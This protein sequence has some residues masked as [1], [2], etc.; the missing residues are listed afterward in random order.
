M[1]I[2]INDIC[3]VTLDGSIVSSTLDVLHQTAPFS[4][5]GDSLFD[6][7]YNLS[8]AQVVVPDFQVGT[9]VH[10]AHVWDID[11]TG[12]LSTKWGRVT[13]SPVGSVS[14]LRSQMDNDVLVVAV[15]PN[16]SVPQNPAPSGPPA[17][18][19]TQKKVRV[20]IQRQGGMPG[21]RAPR[22]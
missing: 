18:G 15:P 13:T 16:V 22:P 17:P 8:E 14:G 2:N 4:S 10:Q 20:K 9:D 21:G 3:P 1:T 6:E 7:L 11:A 12:G 19:T 5:N